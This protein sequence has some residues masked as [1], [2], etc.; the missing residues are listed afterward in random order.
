MVH[1]LADLEH[2]PGR[3]GAGD[4]GH[5]QSEAGPPLTDKEIETVQRGRLDRNT[6]IVPPKRWG[7]SLLVLE[8][9][10]ATMFVEDDRLHERFSLVYDAMVRRDIHIIAEIGL[11]DQE[12]TRDLH[13][14][15]VAAVSTTG[16]GNCF[17]GV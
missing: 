5:L 8:N 1:A 15:P 11:L 10:G 3:I 7:C 13:P 2:D 17:S 16:L 4:V 12:Q 14:R 6:N 9:V